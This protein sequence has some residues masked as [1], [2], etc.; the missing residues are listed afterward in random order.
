MRR[1]PLWPKIALIFGAFLCLP[2]L[3]RAQAT[4]S[5]S[6]QSGAYRAGELFS[7]LL[8]VN[9]GG[10]PINAAAG[11]LNF[12][13]LRMEVVSMGYS[14]S[15]FT[16]WTEEPV[17]SNPAG[18]VRFSGGLPSP[19]F[20]GASGALLRITF[21]PKAAGQA[22]VVFASGSVLAND[23]KGTNILDNL[24]GA[25]F[26]VIQAAEKPKGTPIPAAPSGIAQDIEKL[27][28]VPLITEWPRELEEG[29]V[30]TIKG[31]AFP[32]GKILIFTQKGS[33]DPVIEER[34][35]GSDGRFSYSFSKTVSAGLYRVWA[36]N[37]SAG[38]V[39]SAASEIIT[40]E[41]VQP[42]FFRI[43]TVALNYASIIVTL[44]ALILLLLLIIGWIWWRTR[45]W[46]ERQ[47]IEVDESERALHEGFERLRT[48]L[49]AYLKYLTSAKSPETM[50]RRESRTEEELA[51]ELGAIEKKIEKEM[52]DVG[53]VAEGKR[54]RHRGHEEDQ[55]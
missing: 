21:R 7:V 29:S 13:N 34:F 55:E 9:T 41:V 40:I 14:S 44:L 6:P 46:R 50:K 48:G 53:Q 16:I 4:L 49:R 51:G 38:G 5:V 20:N 17:F 25:L 47:G 2:L 52:E 28:S 12:D 18:T 45:K 22:P 1:F 37:V 19:G 26:N 3:A 42:L 15:I 43:G 8:N 30:L 54:H 24:Q 39:V 33:A 32:N 10:S 31:L 23:G 11:Q 35:A 27:V 36:K